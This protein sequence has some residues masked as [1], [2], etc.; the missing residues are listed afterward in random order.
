MEERQS[1]VTSFGP[2]ISCPNQAVKL[3]N[4]GHRVLCE[5]CVD[6]VKKTTNQCPQCGRK[7]TGIMTDS[8]N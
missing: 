3:S 2:C 6:D 5:K 8:M 1:E 4:C 7:I